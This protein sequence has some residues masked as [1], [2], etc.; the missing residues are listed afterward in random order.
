MVFWCWITGGLGDISV[1]ERVYM[2]GWVFYLYLGRSWTISLT[3]SLP[4]FGKLES[5]SCLMRC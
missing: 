1:G 5:S 3:I 4:L 2:E